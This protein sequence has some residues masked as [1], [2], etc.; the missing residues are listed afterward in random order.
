[1]I[2]PLNFLNLKGAKQYGKLSL[3]ITSCFLLSHCAKLPQSF[4]GDPSAGKNL[5]SHF[6]TASPKVEVVNSL[7]SLFKLSV[8]NTTVRQALENNPD[9]KISA[10]RL[11]EAGYNFEKSQAPLLPTLA[12]SASLGRSYTDTSGTG[13]Y[14][15]SLNASWEVDLWG[16][17]KASVKA[18]DYSK[19]AAQLD[20]EAARQSI[21]AQTMQAWFTLAENDALLNLA[22][23]RRNSFKTTLNLLEKRFELGT[24]NLAAIE[25]AKVDLQNSTF[26]LAQRS[27][28]RD[29]SAR[30]IQILTGNYPS[31]KQSTASFP[32]LNKTVAPNTP[33]SILMRRPDIQAAYRRILAADSSV[34][35]AHADQFPVFN[36]TSS[37]GTSATHLANFAKSG[38][39][40][41]SII[42]GL[43]TPLIDN[44]KR[45]AEL[46]A[47]SARAEQ[48]YYNYK[49]VLLNALAEVENALG[50]DASLKQQQNALKNALT[51]SKAAEQ[52]IKILFENGTVEILTYLDTQRRRFTHEEQLINIKSARY[53]NRVA[54]A[55]AT[56]TG[57]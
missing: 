4:G 32:L 40:T 52:R 18:A 19:A 3:I 15:H 21:A 33:A 10:A 48:A 45:K 31:S 28:T 8:L 35:V 41:F 29:I 16:R 44:G 24:T 39:S 42:G 22:E 54:L 5:P 30:A 34:K 46:G 37:L 49:K 17:V 11:K 25:L 12:H 14:S 57:I 20:H 2:K 43:S 27:N 9:L 13:S 55:L 7:S 26:Q 38:F 6:E 50:N 53:K 36:L 23:R 47:S 1:M 51:S 56:G